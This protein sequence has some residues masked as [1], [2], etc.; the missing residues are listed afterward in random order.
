MS[1]PMGGP[2]MT[3]AFCLILAQYAVCFAEFPLNRAES[4]LSL[5]SIMYHPS[6]HP[7]ISPFAQSFSNILNT[8]YVPGTV[9]GV[10]YTRLDKT[11]S[12][13]PS[14]NHCLS[15]RQTLIQAA[16]IQRGKR[17]DKESTGC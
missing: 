7:P 17:L 2:G 11:D 13:P 14:Q 9:L 6:I 8:Y 3:S 15:G 4:K 16:M 10:G 1:D 12:V 5:T